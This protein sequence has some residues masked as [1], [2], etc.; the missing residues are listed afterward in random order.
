RFVRSVWPAVHRD[1][2]G[3][4]LHVFGGIATGEA[5]GVVA[6][7]P[8]EDSASAFA[9]NGVLVVPLRI[10]SGGPV[11]VLEGGARGGPGV[12]TPEALTGLEVTDG[13]EALVARE[14]GEYV[15]AFR[16]L[17]DEPGLRPALIAGG[18][19]LLRRR[20]DLGH[21]ARALVALYTRA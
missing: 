18:R 1:L 14:P 21:F 4:L 5:P 12:A 10:G 16:R 3:A 19:E 9:P 11:E 7:R 8:P 2:P 17:E 6:H 13:R 20:H 15:A